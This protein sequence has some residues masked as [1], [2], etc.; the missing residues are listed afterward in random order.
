MRFRSFFMET[1][2][3]SVIFINFANVIDK[4][5]LLNYILDIMIF[6][7]RLVAI[8][9]GLSLCYAAEAKQISFEQALAAA[10]AGMM[11]K[12]TR[13]VT[14]PAYTEVAEDL[15]VAYIVNNGNEKGFV[16][17]AADDLMPSV[18][19]YS[20]TGHFDASDIPPSMA[21]WL[22]EYG[23]ELQYAVDNGI[24][25][26][27]LTRAVGLST[28]APL[29]TTKWSQDAPYNDNCPIVDGQAALA[30]C[31]AIAVAQVLAYHKWPEKGTGSNTYTPDNFTNSLTFN[32]GET[33]F[34]WDNM[35]DT[36]T[37]N[38]TAA[39][40]KAVAVLLEAVGNISLMA[41]GKDASGAWL[42]N[43]AYGLINHL[44]YDKDVYKADRVYYPIHEWIALLHNELVN[45]RPIAYSGSNEG[46]GH[47]FVVDGYDNG[48]FHLN[49]GWGG[50]SDGYFLI[51]GLDPVSQGL[52]GSHAGYNMNQEC[53]I[54]LKPDKGESNASYVLQ[55][56]V[57]GS[58][59]TAKSDYT[60]SDVVQFS[61]T[62]NPDSWRNT[63]FCSTFGTNEDAILGVNMTPQSGGE[64]V[65][66]DGGSVKL[67]YKDTWPF[68]QRYSSFS[69]NSSSFPTSGTYTVVPAYKYNNEVKECQTPVGYSNSLKMECSA[70]GVKFSNITVTRTLKV[71]KLSFNSNAYVGK[72]ISLDASL[73]CT[74]TE[75]YANIYG[76]VFDSQGAIKGKL[77]TF[78]STDNTYKDAG[79]LA[80]VA[81]G[82]D[83]DIALEGIFALDNVATPEG[84]YEF[85]LV[86]NDGNRLT[87]DSKTE[88][89]ITAPAS[90]SIRYTFKYSVDSNKYSGSGT[91]SDPYIIS[92]DF[93]IDVTLQCSGGFMDA[94]I[95]FW[96]FYFNAD[97]SINYSGPGLSNSQHDFLLNKGDSSTYTYKLNTSA[98][99]MNRAAAVM[100]Y[101]SGD[102]ITGKYL[103][104]LI[105][106]KRTSAAVGTMSDGVRS[107]V[108]PNPA[109]DYTTVTAKGV[110]LSAEVYNIG[111]ACVIRETGNGS[112]SLDLNVSTLATGHYVIV[113]KTASGLEKH[114]LIKK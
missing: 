105:Y 63:W 56:G 31:T 87:T 93:D 22:S 45:K 99:E 58:L 66:Y 64:T 26:P 102:G 15:N 88:L 40:K 10:P 71:D 79:V 57:Q 53:L 81:E 5:A 104:D 72:K 111:G 44:K 36:Y 24:T 108:Y 113:T 37:S 27:V 41:Y 82:Y 76:A 61:L 28:I 96:G 69:I 98:I 107:T 68:V 50:S 38:A 106:V 91:K 35:L 55:V 32:F 90:G 74:G 20:D 101:L 100:P 103:T 86:D 114:R 16:V 42:Y 23:R 30:G 8:S 9:L 4:D 80:D 78:N 75:Y 14:T 25:N 59:T 33:T 83:C 52:G 49:W 12:S 94:N 2:G 112:E 70:T 89:K 21:Y 46:A 110:I 54:N 84:T 17:L 29:C 39:Q 109:V 65:F 85:A 13:S 60:R 11:Q 6:S 47:S 7:T 51:T 1:I 62:G 73:S 18:L 67:S 3:L 34:D 48:Y 95:R 97:G 43:T 77:C 92:D 19:G